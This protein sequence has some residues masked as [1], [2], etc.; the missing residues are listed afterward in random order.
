MNKMGIPPSGPKGGC[1]TERAIVYA[2]KLC[3]TDKMVSLKELRSR[4]FPQHQLDNWLKMEGAQYMDITILEIVYKAHWGRTDSMDLC[5]LARFAHILGRSSI[6]LDFE[7]NAGYRYLTVVLI[8]CVLTGVCKVSR[9]VDM[10]ELKTKIKEDYKAIVDSM[11]EKLLP[12]R[13]ISMTRKKV[14]QDTEKDWDA[15]MAIPKKD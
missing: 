11:V 14:Q 5:S 1:S 8:A 15:L 7:F 2:G 13:I 9:C 12:L 10:E 4:D 3:T 6:I